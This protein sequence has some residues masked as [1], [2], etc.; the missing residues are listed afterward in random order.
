MRV[1]EP[2]VEAAIAY[3]LVDLALSAPRN[4]FLDIIRTFSNISRTADPEDPQFNNNV[5]RPVYPCT[6]IETFDFRQILTAQTR[7]AKGLKGRP[8]LRDTYLQELLL[9]FTDNGIAIQM[10]ATSHQHRKVIFCYA[11]YIDV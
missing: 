7:L 3:N 6:S 1:A 5:V 4:A 11:V 9:L 8:E 2:A 10:I